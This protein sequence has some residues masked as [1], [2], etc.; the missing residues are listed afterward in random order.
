MPYK[1]EIETVL[2]QNDKVI[3][4]RCRKSVIFGIGQ[5]WG[6]DWVIGEFV[7]TTHGP[8]ILFKRRNEETKEGWPTRKAAEEQLKEWGDECVC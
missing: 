2:D 7:M 4:F 1:K 5:E 6:D 8:A 3:G